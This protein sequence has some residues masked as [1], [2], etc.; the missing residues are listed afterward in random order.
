MSGITTGQLST[1][2]GANALVNLTSGQNNTSVGYSAGS[3]VS[4][5]AQNTCIGS[6]AD[7]TSNSATNRT[8]IGYNASADADNC[9]V[10]G[11][12]SVTLIKPGADNVADLGSSTKRL[13]TG[14]FGS[15]LQLGV[16]SPG[17]AA[18]L[19]GYEQAFAHSTTASGPWA[20]PQT[21]NMTISMLGPKVMLNFPGIS[22]SATVL[23]NIS[24][25]A[26]LP[27]RFRPAAD[28]F[29]PMLVIDN[30]VV[31]AGICA[32]TASTGAVLVQRALSDTRITGSGL[33]GFSKQT[34]CY[35][36]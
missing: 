8:A 35:Q 30:N 9:M 5:G 17:T 21:C 11:N 13:K 15:G 36:V 20:S 7:V 29:Q 16:T 10:L 34:V 27:A 32:I 26:A 6:S 1:G 18:T 14:Y 33:G 12:S 4:T 28:T 25:T 3:V 19:S 24:I 2:M 31:I 23:S 22:S